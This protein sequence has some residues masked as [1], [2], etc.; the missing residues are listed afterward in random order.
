MVSIKGFFG[1]RR[2]WVWLLFFLSILFSIAVID[3][4]QWLDAVWDLAEKISGRTITMHNIQWLFWITIPVGIAMFA[5]S[6]WAIRSKGPVGIGGE[7][8]IKSKKPTETL[9]KMHRRLV[10][11]QEEKASHTKVEPEQWEKALPMLMDKMDLVK[12]EDQP[13]F[14]KDIKRR[15]QKRVSPPSFKQRF[16]FLEFVKHRERVRTTGLQVALEVQKELLQSKEEW[17]IKDVVNI[18]EWLDARNWGIKELRDKDPQWGTL[19]KSISHYFVD[20][21]LRELID[22]HIDASYAYNSYCLITHYSRKYAKGSYALMLHEALVGSPISPEK[23]EI[24][25]S[26]LLGK[27]EKRLAKRK[28][29]I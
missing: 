22:K 18:G 23:M 25:L 27:I 5:I 6:I 29:S 17:T 14:R 12:L 2:W 24:D 28:G 26:E 3:L 16:N 15:I 4:P 1:K 20:A 9:T 10:E 11:L 19:F 7:K 13:K 21:K 8:V